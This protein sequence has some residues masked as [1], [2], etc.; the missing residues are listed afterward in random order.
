[1]V[2][3]AGFVVFVT[4]MWITGAQGEPVEFDMPPPQV[5]NPGDCCKLPQFFPN[6][7]LRKCSEN[8]SRIE[9]HPPPTTPRAPPLPAPLL[10]SITAII[11]RG[12]VRLLLTKHL[13][14]TIKIL[15]L[16]FKSFL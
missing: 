14:F 6:Q 16:D 13:I 12:C 1:M 9:Y 4:V 3:V 11:P 2:K 7:V 10:K 8:Y 5:I 15:I